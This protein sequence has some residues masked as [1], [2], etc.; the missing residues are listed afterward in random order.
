M[1][2]QPS[3]LLKVYHFT[4]F[5]KI[6][7]LPEVRNSPFTFRGK[8]KGHL[9]DKAILSSGALWKHLEISNFT[10]TII[11]IFFICFTALGILKINSHYQLVTASNCDNYNEIW[12]QLGS[13][14]KNYVTFVDGSIIQSVMCVPTLKRSM[15]Y[16]N[17]PLG[18]TSFLTNSFKSKFTGMGKIEGLLCDHEFSLAMKS[19][20]K[21]N[22]Q[23]S[24]PRLSKRL[25]FRSIKIGQKHID[26]AS[27]S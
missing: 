22:F 5:Y 27:C 10:L 2:K 24:Y 9:K 23:K 4:L 1:P 16:E 8:N 11:L 17:I 15:P 25:T 7:K 19:D 14:Q 26:V 20:T 18:G 21:L 13:N 6:N 3:I 12:M